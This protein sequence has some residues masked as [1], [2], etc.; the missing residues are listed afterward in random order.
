MSTALALDER[1]SIRYFNA[2]KDDA[3]PVLNWG[4]R[5]DDGTGA[6]TDLSIFR[7]GTFKDSMGIQHTWEPEHLQQMVF[8]FE[9]L[10]ARGIFPNVPIR[11]DHSFSVENV[12]GYITE[13]TIKDGF[14][15]ASG[16]ITEP[17]AAGKIDRKT[18]RSRSS[19]IGVY[20]TN[21]E[22]FFWP[23][24]FGFAFVDIGAVEGL[25]NN[26]NANSNKFTLITD[27]E[28]TLTTP[29]TSL[30]TFQVGGKA[31]NDHAAVQAHI[32]SLE[33][34]IAANQPAKFNIRGVPTTD[35]TAVQ[36]HITALETSLGEID[37]AARTEYVTGLAKANKI[38][39]PQIESLTAHALSL[40]P[41]QYAAFKTS[42]EAAPVVPA[43]GK[44]GNDIT[45]PNNTITDAGE[46]PDEIEVLEEIV[47]MSRQAGLSEEAVAKTPSFR[48][49]Q[50]LKAQ[51]K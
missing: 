23:V 30:S 41:E 25:F 45:N 18:F 39:A 5:N 29:D 28:T 17:D 20:E 31:T 49:L 46:T 15:Y 21:D 6:F 10:K 48:K 3:K 47:K 13:L 32:T 1:L 40:T 27:K 4:K 14:L 16:D 51:A 34:Q 35:A 22:A 37:A 33:A 26:P 19:E 42:Y 8:N 24:V 36:N 38:G 11:K 2:S 44:H 12:V 9:L 7:V 50:E 43:L